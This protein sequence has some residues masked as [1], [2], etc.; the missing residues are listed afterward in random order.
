[1]QCRDACPTVPRRIPFNVAEHRDQIFVILNRERLEPPLPD[2]PR[3]PVMAMVSVRV[4]CEQPLH[5]SSQ[6]AILIGSQQQM[7]VVGHQAIAEKVDRHP[8]R[9][10]RSRPRRRRRDHQACGKR[11]HGGCPDSGRD[12][13]YHRLRRERFAAWRYGS[14]PGPFYQQSAMSPFSRRDP[15]GAPPRGYNLGRLKPFCLFSRYAPMRRI[16][17][18]IRFASRRLH[19]KTKIAPAQSLQSSSFRAIFVCGRH[20]RCTSTA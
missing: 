9:G 16:V 11:P 1:M 8:V 15:P 18:I 4:S 13:T 10:R 3:G 2:V 14:H 7:E 17:A 19:E 20:R 12:T 5:P 6:V